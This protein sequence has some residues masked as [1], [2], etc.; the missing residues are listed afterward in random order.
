MGYSDSTA[1][2]VNIFLEIT[3]GLLTLL[4]R[5]F[6]PSTRTWFDGLGR[7]LENPP[8]IGH[9]M[10]GANSQWAGW[11]Y[12]FWDALVF[13]LLVGTGYGLI[14]IAGKINTKP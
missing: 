1:Y 7:K 14:I 3:L 4:I 11:G 6:D 2:W 8:F 13:W 9:W 10:F 5:S 12:L